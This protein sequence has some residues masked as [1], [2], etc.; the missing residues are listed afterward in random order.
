M[1]SRQWIE[2]I[3]IEDSD[4]TFDGQFLS[5][6]HEENRKRFGCL[7]AD[8]EENRGRTRYRVL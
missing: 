1:L 5:N 2:I 7:N 8:M 6:L 3:P 4:V